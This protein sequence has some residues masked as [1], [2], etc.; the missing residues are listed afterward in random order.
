MRDVHQRIGVLI[1]H[2]KTPPAEGRD[3]I[4]H[5]RLAR[6]ADLGDITQPR[7]PACLFILGRGLNEALEDAP[8]GRLFPLRLQLSIRVFGVSVQRLGNSTRFVV[9]LNLDLAARFAHG[10]RSSGC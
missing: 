2:Q 7:R 5:V 3:H 9:V 6:E 10:T 1:Q 4:A 8:G